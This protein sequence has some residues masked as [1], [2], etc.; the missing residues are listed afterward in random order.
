MSNY[1]EARQNVWKTIQKAVDCGLIRL[2]AGNFSV[3]TADGNVAITPAGIKYDKLTVEQ[4]AIVDLDGN[5]VDGP[6]RSS[7]ETPMHTAIM[8]NLP[9]VQAICHTHS[10]FAMTFAV[11]GKEIPMINTETLVCGAPLPPCAAGR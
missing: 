7:S 11:L 1:A 4:I 5:H 6:C 3:R 8:R 9:H 2:S 10:P